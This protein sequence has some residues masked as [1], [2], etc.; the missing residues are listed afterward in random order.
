MEQAACALPSTTARGM[1]MKRS[2]SAAAVA[3]VDTERKQ[4]AAAVRRLIAI[5]AVTVGTLLA[6][7]L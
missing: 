7:T 3:Q 1:A 4:R 5:A 2:K 6:G